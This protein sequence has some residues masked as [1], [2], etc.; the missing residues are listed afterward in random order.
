VSTDLVDF[1]TDSHSKADHGPR[2]QSGN[3]GLKA[4]RDTQEPHNTYQIRDS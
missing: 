2:R 3:M 4:L 1:L